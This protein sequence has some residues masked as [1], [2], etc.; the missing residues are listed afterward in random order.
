MKS[1]ETMPGTNERQWKATHILFA[2][3]AVVVVPG[4]WNRVSMLPI[5]SRERESSF[6]YCRCST[7]EEEIKTVALS[8]TYLLIW[9]II[10]CDVCL[11]ASTQDRRTFRTFSR[12]SGQS[13]DWPMWM[14]K[15]LNKATWLLISTM[16]CN[17]NKKKENRDKKIHIQWEIFHGRCLSLV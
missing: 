10:S 14:S 7:A 13:F 3:A 1:V 15:S 11:Q 8:T 17:E 2:A 4:E 12:S 9:V 16:S 5:K 6:S